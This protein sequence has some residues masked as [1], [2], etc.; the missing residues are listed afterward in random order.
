M[1][2]RILKFNRQSQ[3]EAKSIPRTAHFPGYPQYRSLPW[4]PL[5][6]HTSLD[7]HQQCSCCSIFSFLCNV[8]FMIVSPC[9]LA[10]V[11]YVPLRFMASDYPFGICKIF[12]EMMRSCKCFPNVSK[13]KTPTLTYTRANNVIWFIVVC[14]L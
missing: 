8:L 10:I 2:T 14:S 12:S 3:K 11:F 5:V 13:R 1:N 4:I 7:F 9:L 6:P